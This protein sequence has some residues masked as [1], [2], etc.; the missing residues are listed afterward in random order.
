MTNETLLTL[1]STRSHLNEAE[2]WSKCDLIAC[3][4]PSTCDASFW[5]FLQSKHAFSAYSSGILVHSSPPGKFV[6][7][8]CEVIQCVQ[9]PF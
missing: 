1:T 2:I 4:E 8:S 9:I 3:D 6:F 7:M 5:P